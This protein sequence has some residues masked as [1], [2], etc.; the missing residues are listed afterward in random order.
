MHERG[1]KLKECFKIK[2]KSPKCKNISFNK[3]KWFSHFGALGEKGFSLYHQIF[4]YMWVMSIIFLLLFSSYKIS[5]W[6]GIIIEEVELFIKSIHLRM[7]LNSRNFKI[8]NLKKI[9]L[10]LK[11]HYVI[12]SCLV[13]SSLMPRQN[14]YKEIFFLEE[15]NN[16]QQE[17]NCKMEC[18][19]IALIRTKKKKINKQ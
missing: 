12:M 6:M 17:W 18:T 15:C 3:P 10:Y 5:M 2:T 11:C 19:K 9:E 14:S 13:T 7:G 4:T 8:P 16:C 1:S